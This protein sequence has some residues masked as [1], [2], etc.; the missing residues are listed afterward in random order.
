M[1]CLLPRLH[2]LAPLLLDFKQCYLLL[3][4]YNLHFYRFP[5]PD[6]PSL[7]VPNLTVLNDLANTASNPVFNLTPLLRFN[8]L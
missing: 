6:E 5:L 3:A 7:R 8:L 4:L 2:L 1:F